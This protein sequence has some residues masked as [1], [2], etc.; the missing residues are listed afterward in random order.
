MNKKSDIV[1]NLAKASKRSGKRSRISEY[2]A[3]HQLRKAE[4][5]L[6]GRSSAGRSLSAQEIE[7]F[8]KRRT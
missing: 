4:D 6:A 7:D 8:M 1:G 5:I 3:N 2:A